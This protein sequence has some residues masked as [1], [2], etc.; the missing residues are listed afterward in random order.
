[1]LETLISL[2]KKYKILM[3]G[4]GMCNRIHNQMDKFPADIVGNYGLQWAKYNEQTKDI[5]IIKDFK[6]DCDRASVEKRA[7]YIREKYGFTEFKGDSVE[8]HSS[9]CITLALLGTKAEKQ[10][11]LAFDPDRKKRRKIY[12]EVC[13]LFS[14]YEVFVGGSSSFDM[15]P[16]GYNKYLALSK[17][18]E[19]N[20]LSHSEVVYVGDDYGIG[21]NDESVFLSD[22]NYIKVDNFEDFPKTVKHLL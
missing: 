16:K 19:E 22:F 17:Y 1:N 14:D 6:F 9:G 11:K 10:D 2:S 5:D 18:C 4:A 20:G 15:A 13:Q 3:V 8:Y 7:T 12:E 21:G